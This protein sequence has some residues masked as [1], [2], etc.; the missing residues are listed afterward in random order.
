[1][2]LY[3]WN[4]Q[5]LSAGKTNKNTKASL[6]QKESIIT[7]KYQV[8]RSQRP[9]W[10]AIDCRAQIITAF[11]K[12]VRL[13]ETLPAGQVLKRSLMLWVR[14]MLLLTILRN[15][16]LL[17]IYKILSR[18]TLKEVQFLIREALWPKTNKENTLTIKQIY[19][20]VK[21]I[22]CK[23]VIRSHFS[24]KVKILNTILLPDLPNILSQ[25]SLSFLK[26]LWYILTEHK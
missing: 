2:N 15:H 12:R 18:K 23:R 10:L 7:M 20:K 16:Q 17:I 9:K 19:R 24:L 1:M 8:V 14:N 4:K 6:K 25:T 11:Y 3:L 21:S 5:L 13:V 22:M 26:S